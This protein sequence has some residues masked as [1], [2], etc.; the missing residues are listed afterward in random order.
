MT[1]IP[2]PVHELPDGGPWRYRWHSDDGRPCRLEL[3]LAD[4]SALPA[5]GFPVR[6][7]RLVHLDEQ[8][9]TGAEPAV[10]ALPPPR[11]RTLSDRLRALYLLEQ[12]VRLGRTRA[13]AANRM[14]VSDGWLKNTVAWARREGYWTPASSRGAQGGEVTMAGHAL[15][16]SLTSVVTT[17]VLS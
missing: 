1:S 6:L 16:L 5:R 2:G 14:S 4:G 13:Y 15:W 12:Y 9:P 11:R 10:E 8:S 7:L 17:E 3:W